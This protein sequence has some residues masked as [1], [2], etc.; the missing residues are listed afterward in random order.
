MKRITDPTF[1]YIPA[2][3]TDLR[4]TF[5]RI[6]REQMEQ[7]KKDQTDEQERILKVRKFK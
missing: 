3:R 5:S 1:R 2:A 4:L 6:R 7:K